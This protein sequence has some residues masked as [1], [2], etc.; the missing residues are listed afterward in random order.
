MVALTAIHH[1][2]D[3]PGTVV[4]W[5]PSPA[6][7]EKVR[8]APVSDVPP[9]YQQDQH[10]R[11]YRE[12]SADG[13]EM[14]RLLIPA[15]NMPGRCD[16]RA[17]TYVINAYLS[18][19]DTYHSWFEFSDDDRI[20]RRTV[21]NPADIKFVATK[22]GAMGSSQWREH[23]LATP[24]P[25]EW[26]CFRFGVIQRA[27]HFTFYLSVDHLH[28]DAMFIMPLFVEIYMN[29]TALVE[30][31]APIRL[32]EAGRYLEYCARQ[33]E[34]AAAL[35][36]ESPEVRGWIEFLQS[37]AGAQPK[38]PLPLGDS[39][40]PCLGD[41][42]TV[43]L[44]DNHETDRFES[45]CTAAGVRFIGGVF[46]CAAMAE[47]E[48]TGGTQYDVVTP[49]TTRTTPAE[50]VTTG[51]FTG[52]V[53]ISVPVYGQP[54]GEVARAAQGSFDSGMYMA[55][56]PVER[57]M[58]LARSLPGIGTPGPGAAML[59]YLDIGLPPMSPVVM[60][61]WEK[62]NG[63]IYSDLGAAK[64]IGIWVTRR[65]TGTTV[66]IAF[67]DNPIARESAAQYVEALKAMFLEIA[68]GRYATAALAGATVGASGGYFEHLEV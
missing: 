15:W 25:L 6:T 61:Q 53:P 45:A 36:L 52:L 64:Q 17:M 49:T 26:D 41:L 35:T 67:P 39:S 20:V 34:Y 50:F 2:V 1:W 12:H 63:R 60:S 23:V 33:R 18:R 27:D 30:G 10:I 32:P 14:A 47:C 29:Y 43:E 21:N 3:E 7:V 37:N 19:H 42:L 31:G 22:H 9:S 54:F 4:S 58:E 13:V 55:N 16:I 8:N 56:V 24:S 44:M 59:S 38:F 40:V 5:S 68:D 46:A 57:V 51:W 65:G 66:T 28:A 48:L 62:L 11:S